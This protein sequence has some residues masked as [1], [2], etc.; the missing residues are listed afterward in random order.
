MLGAI[1]LFYI[2]T[3]HHS[4]AQNW[5]HINWTGDAYLL[6]FTEVFP[7]LVY[8]LLNC[9]VHHF[10]FCFSQSH[11]EYEWI[12]VKNLHGN[13]ANM[14]KRLCIS[15]YICFEVFIAF[16]LLNLLVDHFT[17]HII[18]RTYFQPFLNSPVS[19]DLCERITFFMWHKSLF[20]LLLLLTFSLSNVHFHT[21]YN[22]T[23]STL[24]TP[25]THLYLW[26]KHKSV[27][28]LRLFISR[29]FVAYMEVRQTL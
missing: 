2:Y 13:R 14:R 19:F 21:R 1:H 9:I 10:E 11:S 12:E 23:K 4:L 8:P 28:A 26:G 16:Y 25:D 27:D 18:I 17:I 6:A 15:F 5:E 20:L 24:L 29:F 7:V 3:E 22:T